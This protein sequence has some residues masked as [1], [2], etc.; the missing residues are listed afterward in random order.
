MLVNHEEMADGSDQ[1][2]GNIRGCFHITDHQGNNPQVMEPRL[3]DVLEAAARAVA[4]PVSN[5][6]AYID[7]NRNHEKVM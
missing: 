2:R 6:D 5:R 4:A 7:G 3:E 1:G